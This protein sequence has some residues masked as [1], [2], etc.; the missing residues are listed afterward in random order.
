MCVILGRGMATRVS[1]G[2]GVRVRRRR[3]GQLLPVTWVTSLSLVP[4]VKRA[5][6]D[7]SA[8]LWGICVKMLCLNHH[9]HSR[10]PY[11]VPGTAVICLDTFTDFSLS[12]NSTR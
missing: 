8:A 6:A 10:G 4:P 9:K 1:R 11:C 3:L 12:N 5:L 7:H 2:V